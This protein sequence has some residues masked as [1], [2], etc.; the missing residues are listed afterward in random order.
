[1]DTAQWIKA[2]SIFAAALDCD[3]GMRASF[4]RQACGHDDTLRLELESLLSAYDASDGLSKPP[5]F[6]L[7]WVDA[8]IEGKAIG[9]YQLIRKLG[10][11]GMGQ[12]WLADQVGPV[13][14][15]VAL[16]LIRVGAYDDVVLRRFQAERQSLAMMDHPAI[17]KVFDAGA[18]PDGQ[19]FFVMEYVPGLPI[20]E[21][22]DQKKLTI[23]ERLELLLAACDGVQHAHQKA[24]IHRDLK[25]ANILVVEVDGK[26]MPRIIDFGL[27]KAATPMDEQSMFTRVGSFVG[28]P[29]YM[30]PEQADWDNHDVDTRT[31]VYSLGVVLYELLTG[32]LPFGA[33]EKRPLDEVLRQVREEDPP[34]P[35][36]RIVAAGSE[37]ADARGTEARQLANQL[38]GDLDCITLKAV[39][40]DRGRRY[41]SPMELAEDIQR[42]LRNEPVQ[43]QPASRAYQL[44]K[45]VRRHRIGVAATAIIAMLLAGSAIVQ[46]VDLRRITRERDRANRITDF[47]TS[48][49][50]VA[51]PS[52]ARGNNIKV[53]EI[54][55]KAAKD[56]DTGLAKDP[57]LQAQM[58]DVIGGVYSSLGLYSSAQPMFERA[59]EI[60]T[61]VDGADSPKQLASNRSL[62]ETIGTRGRY[63]DAEALA[64]HTVE[65]SRRVLGARHVE[66][67]RS[68]A[69]LAVVDENLAHLK[70]AEQ[71][72]RDAL[73]IARRT[74]GEDD[75]DTLRP[76]NGLGNV[77]QRQARYAEAEP[78]HA[79]VLAIRQQKLGR[80]HPQTLVAMQGLASDLRGE[81]KL[82][83]AEKLDREVYEIRRRILG[84]D[85]QHTLS[86]MRD[87]ARDVGR[88]GR[89]AEAEQ[90]NRQAL[91]ITR[92]VMGP[93]HMDSV[94][95]MIN[96]AL[97][98]MREGQYAESEQ[99]NRTAIEINR[100]RLGPEHPYTLAPMSNLA[101]VLAKDH[102]PE[103]AESI[104]RQTLDVE[105]RTLGPQNPTT[106]DTMI[107]ILLCLQ[108][109]QKYAEGET[110]ARQIID[111]ERR[112]F[113][114]SDARTAD[115][116]YDL[117]S[118]LAAQGR[119]EETIS[120][121]EDAVHH[122]LRPERL[123]MLSTDPDFKSLHSE[124][125]FKA[126]VVEATQRAA[127]TTKPQGK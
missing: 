83:D 17:A 14:R 71:L 93:E 37:A 108:K 114:A 53:R 33:K 99:L 80:E 34:R 120:V 98:L 13:R 57:E 70:E 47:M 74:L 85:H 78:Y 27:A 10:E 36:A 92:R 1:M 16:K 28:T 29:G 49:F 82:A 75:P 121:L 67:L 91:E 18:T 117:G 60:W 8:P 23:R 55:D 110:L 56:L 119:R 106:I 87:L 97:M 95:L 127:A 102:K 125:G 100:R 65:A 115:T 21:Y 64:R 44:R 69:V 86:A 66:T 103:E 76:M 122:G 42:Y 22:S 105:M 118:F 52:E 107:V 113:G 104:A 20:T 40:R 38:R 9:S 73:D 26:R 32:M 61:R 50:K 124:P 12:V 58:M 48:M 126:L 5:W 81:G 59:V 89:Y 84:M 94:S 63:V 116:V 11:G 41:G 101:F 3:P 96:L 90:I 25:P 43:A 4:L 109:Q 24:I 30:S 31:D 68:M 2:K 72:D 79:R 19:P 51:D 77:L 88:Q 35:S 15:Q 62:A 6:D 54:L 46:A 45:Y 39:E 112:A 7:P 111:I 123:A